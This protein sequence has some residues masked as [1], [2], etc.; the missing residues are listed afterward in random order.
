MAT[1]IL[2]EVKYNCPTNIDEIPSKSYMDSIM[3]MVSNKKTYVY[4]VSPI[5][6]KTIRDN[7][8]IVGF[9]ATEPTTFTFNFG[10]NISLNKT[11]KEGEFQYALYNNVCPHISAPFSK[12]T[13]SNLKGSGYI[14]YANLDLELRK[15][16]LNT[17]YKLE[18][19]FF[20]NGLV[21]PDIYIDSLSET[22]TRLKEIRNYMNT[23]LNTFHK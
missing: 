9:I 14:I 12:I 19:N 7:D 13:I 4:C 22:D 8:I 23:C 3:D 18:S 15:I 1:E 17:E 5:L 11:L 10:Y 6:N 16:I 20:A 21:I 2:K